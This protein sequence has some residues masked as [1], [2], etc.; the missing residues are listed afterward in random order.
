MHEN[1]NIGILLSSYNV[2]DLTDA[3]GCFCAKILGDLGAKVNRIEKSGFKKD[4]WWTAYNSNKKIIE[5]DSILL[6]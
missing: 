2:L 4:T 1:Q 6:N 5:L 3:N